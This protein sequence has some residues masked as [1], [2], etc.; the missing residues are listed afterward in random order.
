MLSVS[1]GLR[2]GANFCVNMVRHTEPTRTA[3]SHSCVSCV[4]GSRTGATSASASATA[5]GEVEV[6]VGEGAPAT[7]ALCAEV[8]VVVAMCL[9]VVRVSG[10]GP[11]RV[12]SEHFPKKESGTC[13]SE[14]AV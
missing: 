12:K 4:S 7:A 6:C 5:T 10:P 8:G 9:C 14:E 13:A 2:W 1:L 11:T 3:L